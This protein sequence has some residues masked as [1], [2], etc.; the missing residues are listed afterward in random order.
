M[1]AIS[2]TIS[3]VLAII[4]GIVI[5]VFPSVLRWAIGLYLIVF[6]ILQ[7]VGNYALFSPF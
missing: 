4:L 6:G 7:L 5:L 1:V 3:A 2:L